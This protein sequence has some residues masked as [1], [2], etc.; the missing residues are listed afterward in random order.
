MKVDEKKEAT[1]EIKKEPQLK[2]FNSSIVY[3]EEFYNKFEDFEEEGNEG[4]ELTSGMQ[5]QENLY[6]QVRIFFKKNKN[7]F[8]KLNRMKIRT[9][10][11]L[12]K[13]FSLF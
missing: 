1:T 10:K 5:F 12:N 8:R 9:F 11:P 2:M 6:N 13:I 7:M 4:S 3:D